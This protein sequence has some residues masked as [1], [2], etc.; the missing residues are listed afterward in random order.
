MLKY[1]N[2]LENYP[3]NLDGKFPDE[4]VNRVPLALKLMGYYCF[5]IMT[6]GAYL[7]KN[8]KSTP[9]LDG[10]ESELDYKSLEKMYHN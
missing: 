7:I 9:L 10:R 5:I 8:V 2:N 6:A 3:K 1:T 4:V